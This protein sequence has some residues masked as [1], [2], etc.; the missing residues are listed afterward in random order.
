MTFL[1]TDFIAQ[2]GTGAQGKTGTDGRLREATAGFLV[3]ALRP[4]LLILRCIRHTDA[5]A[6][7]DNNPS[8]VERISVWVSLFLKLLYR[9][10]EDGL[11]CRQIEPFP[12]L[13][14]RCC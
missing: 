4:H 8:T 7:N 14:V 12:G 5:G 1:V 3:A 9:V 2:Q 11:Q 10:E 13:A 6:V